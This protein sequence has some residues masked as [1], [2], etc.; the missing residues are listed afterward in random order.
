MFLNIIMLAGVGGAAVPLVLHLLSRARYKVAPWGAMVFLQ[1][2]E[3]VQ[4]QGIRLRQGILLSVRMTV[5]AL[6]AIAL[7]R[8][9]A[10]GGAGAL[11]QQANLTAVILLDNSGS[12]SYGPT[13]RS[14][15]DQARET[16][17]QILL[18]LHRGDQAALVV[19]GDP[20]H[21]SPAPQPTA[22]L[23]SVGDMLDSPRLQV[24]GY[25]VADMAEGLKLAAD[26]L[27]RSGS[28]RREL[29]IICDRQAINWR[30]V[31]DDFTSL[32][33]ARTRTWGI[34]PKFLV[35]PVGGEESDNVSIESLQTSE[36]QLLAGQNGE[37][38]ISL[39]NYGSSARVGIPLTI[40]VDDRVIVTQSVNVP[41][42]ASTTILQTVNIKSP[43]SHVISARIK[44]FDAE[45]DNRLG[46]AVD[47][48]N[49]INVLIIRD[50]PDRSPD[51]LK[52]ALMPFS[53][54]GRGGWDLAI[55]R[56][57][58]AASLDWN[59]LDSRQSPVVIL[60]NVAQLTSSQTQAL[61]QLVYGGAGLLV[62][63]GAQTVVENLNKMLY[64]DGAG[65]LPAWL[66]SPTPADASASTTLGSVDRSH[67]IL[68]FISAAPDQ[69]PRAEISRYFPAKTRPSDAQ[70]IA[71][72]ASSEPFL[73]VG[74]FGR[75]H[76]VV[77]TTPLDGRWC[78]LPRTGFYLPL[79][80]SIARFLATQPDRNL[81]PGQ[82]IVAR[83]DD[84]A[85]LA[86]IAAAQV[87]TPTGKRVDVPLQSAGD[88]FEGRF[89]E[90]ADTG[91]YIV[92]TRRQTEHFVV[93]PPRDEADL[94]PLT[95]QRFD[96]LASLLGFSI[97]DPTQTPLDSI[98]TNDRAPRELW[99]GLLAAVL[100]LG[101]TEV[102]LGRLW[103]DV[104]G[105]PRFKVGTVS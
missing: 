42:G 7:A 15:G 63:P 12:M 58:S 96:E 16:A 67:P 27:E 4:R 97:V 17:R 46:R 33:R 38:S 40:D 104:A 54:A 78:E 53:S 72:Y 35:I 71:S 28:S 61:E 59:T 9:V 24:P 25:G 90:T 21:P 92:S 13:S 100:G 56:A 11:G 45:G 32:W 83:F 95:Q 93:S 101:I 73:I 105:K 86:G 77:S 34:P 69:I 20:A 19:M 76:V 65:L 52:F 41:P 10:E 50:V 37:L 64:R 66:A 103:S 70:V 2:E 87:L 39:H 29:V 62:S 80:Q 8:P 98:L 81:A 74:N 36:P 91:I 23:Q 49:P 48:I 14:R 6:L 5:V 94:T 47:V 1:G 31:S 60:D 88:Q 75:G 57:V 82:P 68:H 30:G 85:G 99:A 102:L 55:V 3:I 43:G 22:D 84:D 51:Y 18:T 79:V 44:A 89:T 26:V